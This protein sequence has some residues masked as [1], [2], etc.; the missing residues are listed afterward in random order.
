MGR[1]RLR[2]LDISLLRRMLLLLGCLLF[3]WSVV[4]PLYNYTPMTM[5]ESHYSIL[6]WSFK[7]EI[8][9]YGFLTLEGVTQKW[10]FDY[11]FGDSYRN[12]SGSSWLFLAMFVTQIV[13]LAMGIVLVFN[14]KKTIAAVQ[15]AACLTTMLLMGYQNILLSGS[16]VI[17]YS[18]QLGYW[19]TYPSL[20][21][22]IINFVL[23]LVLPPPKMR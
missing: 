23:T 22:F 7:V 4:V 16:N 9:R 19:L 8:R 15:A 1:N 11:W 21:L 6:Y 14:A 3:S 10:F 18:Y 13:T 2:F 20:V 17:V 5:I 12:F